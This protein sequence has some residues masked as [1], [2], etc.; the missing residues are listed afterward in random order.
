MKADYHLHTFF[1]NDSNYCMET[2]IKDAIDLNLD[3]IC[4]TEHVDYGVK[5]NRNDPSIDLNTIN[6][7]LL[8]VDYQK[9]IETINNLKKQYQD[10][11]NIKIGM[12]FG[13][14]SITINQYNELFNKLPLDFVILSIHQVNNEEFHTNEFQQG[15][16]EQEFYQAYYEELYKVV[17]NYHNYCVLGHMDLIKRYDFKD[18]YPSFENHKEIITKILK[19]I[20]EDG[21]G[22]EINTSSFRYGLDDLTPSIDILKLYKELGGKIITIG[23]DAHNANHFK[24]NHFKEVKAALRKLGFK[25]FCTFDKMQPTFHKL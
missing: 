24:N 3:E 23:S 6:P 25:E 20:I 11:I 19:Y 15:R 8:N 16:S 5:F 14:Q 10:K 4:F 12:E 13:V 7:K 21:K 22:I 18:N 17:Q 2:C 9:Y 1:S